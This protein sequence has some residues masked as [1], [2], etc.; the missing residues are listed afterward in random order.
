MRAPAPTAS[1]WGS[2]KPEARTLRVRLNRM[3][4]Q[5]PPDRPPHHPRAS[6]RMDARLDAMTRPK[7]DDLARRFHRPRA[8]VLSHIMRWGLSYDQGGAPDPGT[9][10]GP[11]RHLYCYVDAD[12]YDAVRKAAAAAGVQ[13]AP[14]LRQMVRHTCQ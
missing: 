10:Q 11:V 14:W 4:V 8:A 9:S 2:A 5:A 13:L 7:V 6:I 3:P 12:L 1:G